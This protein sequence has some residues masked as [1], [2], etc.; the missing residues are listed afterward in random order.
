MPELHNRAVSS[1][2]FSDI[3]PAIRDAIDVGLDGGLIRAMFNALS[4]RRATRG[5]TRSELQPFWL[6]RIFWAS[7]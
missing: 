6:K 4:R 3:R 7:R 5:L 2:H 1:T